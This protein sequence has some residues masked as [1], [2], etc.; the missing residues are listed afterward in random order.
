M[1]TKNTKDIRSLSQIKLIDKLIT[2]MQKKKLSSGSIKSASA[3]IQALAERLNISDD[4]ATIFPAFFDN[5]SDSRILISEIASFYDCNPVKILTY[6]SAIEELIQCQLLNQTK[7]SDGDIF[8]SI[9]DEV[10]EAIRSNKV[11]KPKEY[12]DLNNDQWITE[13]HQLLEK[14]K[15]NRISYETFKCVLLQLI[16]RN[17][18]LAIAKELGAISCMDE[19]IILI[20][21][22]NLFI[23]NNDERIVQ[24]DIENLLEFPWDMRSYARQLEQGTHPLQQA[25]LV[26][27]SEDDGMSMKNAWKLTNEAKLRFLK[28]ID[29]SSSIGENHDR[30]ITTELKV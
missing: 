5:F 10:V 20:V 24:T 22:I 2:T 11:Y 15:Y 12:K 3:Y 26:E 23:Q 17:M 9:P 14:K 7:D 16:N 25:G 30:N 1:K 18:H 27:H 29:T 19:L 28:E 13:L 4:A 21:M 6:W 8:F